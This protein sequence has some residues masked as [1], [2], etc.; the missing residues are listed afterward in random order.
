MPE[1]PS[2]SIEFKNV[3]IIVKGV[4]AKE[5]DKIKTVGNSIT[6]IV[7]TIANIFRS[8]GDARPVHRLHDVSVN[9]PAGSAT[10]VLAP[11]G[12]GKSSFLQATAGILQPTKGKILYNGKMAK[13]SESR[14][15]RITAF[16]GQ[17][18]LHLPQLTVRETLMFAAQNAN[19]TG[20]LPN[21]ELIR[22]YNE[23]RV[24]LLLRILGLTNCADTIVGND[25]VR[26]VS[27]G[28]KRRVSIG[29]Q[30]ITNAR[31][32]CLDQYSTGLDTSTTI[33]ITRSLIAWA[34]ITGGTVVASMLQPPPEV[35]EMYDNILILRSGQLVY[36]G[37]RDELRPFLVDAGFFCPKEM[38][39]ADIVTEIV[40]HPMS[41]VR[42]FR[43]EHVNHHKSNYSLQQLMNT[44]DDENVATLSIPTTSHKMHEYYNSKR[45]ELMPKIP[46]AGS[47]TKAG[48]PGVINN[49]HLV[50]DYSRAQ[51][52]RA[53]AKSFFKQ[54]K[55]N[56]QRQ[57]RLM[58]RN[59]EF[60]IGHLVQS[61]VFPLVLGSLFWDLKPDQ[62]QL[63]FG[64]LLFIPSN[65]A[66]TNMAELPVAI[67]ARSVVYRQHFAGF[68]STLA[69]SLAANVV[70][71]PIA[72]LE[73]VIFSSGLYWMTGF[74]Q[75]VDRFFF[76]ILN[77]FFI[78]LAASNLFRFISYA[79]PTITL[80]QVV[81]APAV[82]MLVMFSGIPITRTNI[83]NVFIWLYYLSPFSW[84]IRSLAINEYQSD[85]FSD[86]IPGTNTT[87]GELYM[88]AYDMQFGDDWKW[89]GILFLIGFLC[90]IIWACHFIL[91]RGKPTGS[92]GTSRTHEL[93]DENLVFS[94][95]DI[96]DEEN[97]EMEVRISGSN[98]DTDACIS[99]LDTT[100]SIP[101]TQSAHAIPFEPVSLVF[102]RLCYDVSV[103]NERGQSEKKRLLCD[104]CGYARPGEL[105][106]LMGVTG[107]GKTTLLDV[108]ARRKTGGEVIG[109]VLMNGTVPS[110]RRFAR[111]VGYC[112]QNDLHEPYSTVEEALN[113]SAALRLPATVPSKKRKAFVKEI[114]ELIELDAL[115]NRVIGWPGTDAGLS[116]GQR[117]RL[118][119]GVELV[120]NTSILFLD[121]P[122]SG[123]DSREA[124]VVM[125]VVRNV[126]RT[127]RT[128]IC[129]IHQPNS[130]LF[131]M[132]GCFFSLK[133]ERLFF[134][135]PSSIFNHT[136]RAF[137][138]SR[139]RRSMLTQL[140]GCW[141]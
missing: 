35:V 41:W 113:F 70:Q 125:R 20:H 78:A 104:V 122:T 107:A 53:H 120:A 10:L 118:T 121:E 49:G 108:L 95:A 99:P 102:K 56:V 66:F 5:N 6:G 16:V 17:D 97:D 84:S 85:T 21:T 62:F 76:F 119:L 3:D 57:F 60:L 116:Q 131:A 19:V 23:E 73:A 96:S 88:D 29:E 8:S 109:D 59:S 65:L 34:H 18:D 54:F 71:L 138:V 22:C 38:D 100:I 80:G 39:T 81:V 1:V 44:G 58:R 135:D 67:S 47:L 51:Y 63:R 126:A 134:M 129:T 127:D 45:D 7:G 25:S 12:H 90:S 133:V 124:E 15:N 137:R 93:D 69:Y 43:N 61:I 87:R 37:S 4:Q 46:V 64:L 139:R 74:S 48:T 9:L 115:R 32:I 33:D 42:K 132:F 128:V 36:A 92:R 111:L 27:G 117:K 14:V 52:G 98:V 94:F 130:E 123:L 103:K 82:G 26:G 77:M 24:D 11:P 28:E 83:P 89:Y 68:Y 140:H 112:E 72:L 114:M 31:V 30:L 136:L 40:T 13:D 50:N 55:Y 106:A 141:T 101:K 75:D 91:S 110:Q 105:T 86:I 2:C 79:V